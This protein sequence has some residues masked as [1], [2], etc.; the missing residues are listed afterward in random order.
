MATNNHSLF[1]VFGIE[2]EYML[3]NKTTLSIQPIADEVIKSISGAYGY[4]MSHTCYPS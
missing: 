2:I 3:V 4:L 1:S